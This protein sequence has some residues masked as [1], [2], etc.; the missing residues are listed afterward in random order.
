MKRTF[1]LILSFLGIGAFAI[2]IVIACC[3]L[4]HKRGKKESSEIDKRE[5]KKWMLKQGSMK[6]LFD[7]WTFQSY[8][9]D[10][11]LKKAKVSNGYI[12]FAKNRVSGY[13]GCNRYNFSI[14]KVEDY[15]LVVEAGISATKRACEDS[16]IMDMEELYLKILGRANAFEVDKN[17]LTIYCDK[18]NKLIFTRAIS[19]KK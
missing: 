7:D 2:V 17:K 1:L 9:M 8:E 14:K 15:G 10:G 12:R 11:D 13:S 19:K 18:G 5:F 4:C 16:K 3:D 6:N